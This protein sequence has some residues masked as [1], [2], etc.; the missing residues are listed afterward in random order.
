MVLHGHHPTTELR[1][2][3]S[4]CVDQLCI[5]QRQEKLHS[6]PHAR[7]L[8]P[9]H[10]HEQPRPPPSPWQLRQIPTLQAGRHMDCPL[11]GCKF[12]WRHPMFRFVVVGRQRD[13]CA[14]QHYRP[15]DPKTQSKLRNTRDTHGE[16]VQKKGTS[17][18]SSSLSPKTAAD[19]FRLERKACSSPL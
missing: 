12:T 2:V 16:C 8:V 17:S 19:A 15:A 9:H 18:P 1:S 3:L 7:K 5:S 10:S 14:A 11:Q 6:T 4:H 13:W